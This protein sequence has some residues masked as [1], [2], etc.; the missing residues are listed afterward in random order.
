MADY[1]ATADV[2]RELPGITIDV[3]TKPSITEVDQF[4]SDITVDMDARMRA[5]GIPVSI[6]DTD[7]L[8]F[9]TPIAING[10]KAKVLRA[11]VE[12]EQDTAAIYETLYQD[13]MRRIE[14]RPSIIRETDSPG[15]PEGTSRDDEDIR[16]TRTG[17]EW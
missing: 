13:A 7:L 15:Q 9:L 10:V 12:G 5:V 1:C 16:F 4:C 2:I 3:T 17:E 8:K 14:Q 11:N 6:T